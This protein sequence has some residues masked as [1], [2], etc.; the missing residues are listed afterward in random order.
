MFAAVLVEGVVEEFVG[1]LLGEVWLPVVL[2]E[3]CL[4]SSD[5]DAVAALVEY[6]GDA[7]FEGLLFGA[8]VERDADV[9]T[10]EVLRVAW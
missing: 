2:G 10:G 3:L 8:S 9:A 1:V 6:L 5:D 4:S 7:R